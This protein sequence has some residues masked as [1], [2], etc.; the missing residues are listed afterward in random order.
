M[1][2]YYC[3]NCNK[4]LTVTHFKLCSLCHQKYVFKSINEP[5]ISTSKVKYNTIE[6]MYF[7]SKAVRQYTPNK[8]QSGQRATRVP[9]SVPEATVDRSL[10]LMER[11]II[12]YMG[13]YHS[14]V[15]KVLHANDNKFLRRI[16]FNVCLYFIAYHIKPISLFLSEQ[17]FITSLIN[18]IYL[19]IRR[20]QFKHY[21]K[22]FVP[23][24]LKTVKSRI[25]FHERSRGFSI[26]RQLEFLSIVTDAVAPI[27]KHYGD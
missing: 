10:V 6:Y 24:H 4:P 26:G 8:E 1:K 16:L 22:D 12:T 19:E 14:E 7:L 5:N 9:I 21:K 23:K 3:E 2:Y 27:L 20:T 17:N 15:F 18:S 11:A 13:E 25:G